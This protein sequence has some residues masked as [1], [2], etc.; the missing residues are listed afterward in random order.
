MPLTWEA[1]LDT[2]KFNLFDL[3]DFQV[4]GFVLVW[5]F[6][7]TFMYLSFLFFIFYSLFSGSVICAFD[8]GGYSLTGFHVG[9]F[10]TSFVLPVI[11]I[12]LM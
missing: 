11:L 1:T 3:L 7:R 8:L 5:I 9:F 4:L 2:A 6:S 12:I 10:A